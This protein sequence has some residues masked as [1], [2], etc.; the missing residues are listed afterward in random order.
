[1]TDE[2]ECINF[3]WKVVV[4][5]AIILGIICFVCETGPL[6]YLVIIILTSTY[7]GQLYF[8]RVKVSNVGN[9]FSGE[10]EL[11]LQAHDNIKDVFQYLN[12]ELVDQYG[13]IQNEND[14]LRSILSNAIENLISSFTRLEKDASRQHEVA[15]ELTGDKKES[16]SESSARSVSFATLFT[17]IDQVMKKLLD[18]AVTNQ[19]DADLVAEQTRK[20]RHDF[21]QVLNLLGEVKKIADQT[22]LLAINAAVESARA[23]AAG[24]GF[25]VVAEEVRNLSIRSNRFSDEIDKTVRSISEALGGVESSVVSLAEKSGALVD[26]ERQKISDLMLQA[27]EYQNLVGSSAQEITTLSKSLSSSVGQAVTSLQFQDMSSQIIDTVNKRLDSSKSLLE[28]LVNLPEHAIHEPAQPQH[29]H[30]HR[31]TG[32]LASAMELVQDYHHNPV[33]QKSM[34]EGEIELF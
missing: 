14:Q 27:R 4:L 22:N 17:T 33:S 20:T 26:E 21:Q 30:L 9:L 1:M 6:P 23:G 2:T 31:L 11:S 34:D 7:L 19:G 12:R 8:L 28:N 24:R 5:L 3:F 25:A 13:N 29:S 15:I 10:Q 16:L 18:A 32:L